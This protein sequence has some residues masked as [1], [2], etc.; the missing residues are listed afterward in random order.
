MEDNNILTIEMVPSTSWYSN[1]RS[2]V[3]T[4]KWDAIRRKCYSRANNKCEICGDVG[5][6]QG[7]V[8]KVECHEIWDYDDSTL[9]QK[10]IGLI[11]LCPYC[12]KTKHV[13]LATIRGEEEIVIK[14]LM[15]VNKITRKAAKEYITK[16]FEKYHNRS[17]FKWELDITMLGDYI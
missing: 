6:N 3:T 15:K 14:Q 7:F 9:T 1:V 2:N 17:K 5:T 10:L 11:A 8:H 13:G 12:H 16:S 4:E